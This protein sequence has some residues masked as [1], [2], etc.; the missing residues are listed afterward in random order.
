MSS[1]ELGKLQ[2]SCETFDPKGYQAFI[3]CQS[4]FNRQSLVPWSISHDR[5]VCISLM[6]RL[7][8]AL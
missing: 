8:S 4:I 2:G 5:N 7:S 3:W 1:D 6:V